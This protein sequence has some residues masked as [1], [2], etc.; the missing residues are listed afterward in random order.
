MIRQ[1][2]NRFDVLGCYSYRV[3]KP[4][5]SQYVEHKEQCSQRICFMALPLGQWCVFYPS[6]KVGQ[7]KPSPLEESAMHGCS[8][9]P[10]IPS[11]WYF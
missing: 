4:L 11:E 10:W 8:T 3:S 2:G 9:Q 7:S 6:Q 1:T 5:C